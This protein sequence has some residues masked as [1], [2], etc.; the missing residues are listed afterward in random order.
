MKTKTAAQTYQ[1]QEVISESLLP[2]RALALQYRIE[3]EIINDIASFITVVGDGRTQKRLLQLVLATT[4]KYSKASKIRFTTKQL[5]QT[6]KD[7][8]V[9]FSLV[10]NGVVR[11][12]NSE[13]FGY[14]RSL[15]TART[16]IEELGGKSELI[17]S[18]GLNTTLKF[19]IRFEWQKASS[20]NEVSN[21]E[22][23]RLEGKKIL[24]AEDNEVNQKVIRQT[25]HKQGAITDVVSDGKDAVNAFEKSPGAYDLILMDL[26]M[27]YMDGFQAAHY[28]R[29]KLCSSIPIIG[30]T[31]GVP[32]VDYAKC[33][34]A[35]INHFIK[36][37]FTEQELLMAI[38]K[39][40]E[41][42]YETAC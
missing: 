22:N 37:P 18:P 34:E 19:I 13:N 26:Q 32:D 33:V 36:K 21:F 28:I 2:C 41:I 23:I 30:L 12:L 15:I 14:F 16:L 39:F 20:A 11:K 27:S 7:A 42:R 24:L 25:L 5:L 29:K 3:L 17:A 9:E 6:D 38:H 10:D 35:G 4:V 40:S 8:L 1:L 31:V